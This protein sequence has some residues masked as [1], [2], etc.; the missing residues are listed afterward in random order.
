MEFTNDRGQTTKDLAETKS[1]KTST[2][3]LLLLHRYRTIPPFLFQDILQF[4]DLH[5]INDKGNKG[6]KRQNRIQQETHNNA[7]LH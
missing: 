5:I 4:I 6:P 1:K 7:H 3:S 2:H